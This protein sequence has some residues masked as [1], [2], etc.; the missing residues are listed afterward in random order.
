M[1]SGGGESESAKRRAGAREEAAA[2]LLVLPVLSAERSESI[3]QEIDAMMEPGWLSDCIAND[4]DDV[5]G[6]W[7]RALQMAGNTVVQVPPQIG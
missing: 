2:L 5:R 3:F 4:I 7:L 6:S 1:T